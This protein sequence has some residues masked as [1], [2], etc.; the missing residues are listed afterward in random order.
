VDQHTILNGEN[1]NKISKLGRRATVRVD[2]EPQDE[3]K[4]KVWEAECWQGDHT[5]A[6]MMSLTGA[7]GGARSCR[8]SGARG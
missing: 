5:G 7:K 4:C 8:G 1:K 6:R 2:G 3:I